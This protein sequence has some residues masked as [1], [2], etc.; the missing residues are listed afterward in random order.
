M[1][2]EL[3]ER[4]TKAMLALSDELYELKNSIEKAN[5][6]LQEVTTEYFQRYDRDKTE[7]RAYILYDFDRA[8]LYASVVDDYVY[9]AKKTINALIKINESEEE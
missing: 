2:K 4:K 3:Q 9:N 7:E 1:N 6:L 8:A 5:T